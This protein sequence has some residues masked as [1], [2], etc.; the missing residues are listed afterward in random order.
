[1]TG[2]LALL[3]SLMKNVIEDSMNVVLETNLETNIALGIVASEGLSSRGRRFESRRL[4][5]KKK[6]TQKFVRIFSEKKR[7]KT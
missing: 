6:G 5:M 2:L 4:E 1:M 3:Y 7:S